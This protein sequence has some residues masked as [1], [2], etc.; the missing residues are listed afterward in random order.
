MRG[1]EQMHNKIITL[2]SV[3]INAVKKELSSDNVWVLDIDGT[4][5][6]CLSEYLHTISK[7]FLFPTQPSGLDSYNDWICD[8]TWLD[9][10]LKIAIIIYHFSKFLKDDLSAKAHILEDFENMILPWWE[11]DV[12]N[13][14]VDG[15]PR[16]FSVY[17]I[18]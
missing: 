14:V 16:F 8:L 1:N 17:L 11:T 4:R 7:F 3:S 9:A 12:I 13:H 18:D 10:N 2:S 6:S 5:C 15:K